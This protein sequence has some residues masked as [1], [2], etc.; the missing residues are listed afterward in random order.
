MAGLLVIGSLTAMAQCTNPIQASLTRAQPVRVIVVDSDGVEHHFVPEQPVP[1]VTPSPTPPPTIA[2][3]P[4]IPPTPTPEPPQD[5]GRFQIFQTHPTAGEGEP[6]HILWSWFLSREPVLDFPITQREKDEFLFNQGRSRWQDG[7]N[8]FTPFGPANSDRISYATAYAC[9]NHED[10]G[11]HP[12]LCALRVQWQKY[13]QEGGLINDQGMREDP[14]GLG[15]E[16]QG[17]PPYDYESGMTVAVDRSLPCPCQ[18]QLLHLRG[19]NQTGA[20]SREQRLRVIEVQNNGKMH[21]YYQLGGLFVG[22]HDDLGTTT[23]IIISGIHPAYS[24]RVTR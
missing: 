3:T 22:V 1:T 5:G 9:L 10:P 14:F 6:G 20:H 7:P 16:T 19:G 13:G 12:F 23:R 24:Y 2:P 21:W 4:T 11:H 17:L 8:Q 18:I 15:R